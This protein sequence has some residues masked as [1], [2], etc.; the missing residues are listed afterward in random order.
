M[1]TL[2]NSF[3]NPSNFELAW[4]RVASNQGCAGVDGETIREFGQH[5]E[6]NLLRLLQAVARGTYQPLPLR[7]IFI[8]KPGGGWRELRVPAVRD[9]IVQQALL[10]VLH[11]ALEPEFEPSSYAYRPG[12]SHLMAVD[13]VGRWRDQGYS[14]VLDADIVK[15][16]D[17]IQHPRLVTEVRERLAEPWIID[18]IKG[19]I[20]AGVLT[21]GGIVLPQRGVP[22]GAVISPL[23]SNIYL[24]DFDEVLADQLWKLVRFADDFVLMARTQ[25]HIQAGH[26]QVKHLLEAAGLELHPEKTQITHFEQ[27]FRFLGHTFVGDLIVPNRPRPRSPEPQARISTPELTLI[28]AEATGRGPTAMQRALVEALKQSEQPIPPPLFV[29]LGY[30]VRPHARIEIN[31]KELNWREDMASLY[32]VEQGTYLKKGKGRFTLKA[33][34]TKEVL[35][36]PIEEV[37]RILV[38]GNIHLSSAVINSCLKRQ[39]PIIFLSQTGE[40]KGHLW[41]AEITDLTAQA[42]QFARQH[43]EDFQC[44]TARAIVYGKLWNSKLLLVR[45]NYKRQL[46]EVSTTIERLNAALETLAFVDSSHSLEQLRGY[47]GNG[48]S[49]YFQTFN[50]LITNPGFSWQGRNFHPPTDPVNS[51]LSF[52]YTL[53]FNNVFSLLLV[54]GLNPYLGNLHRAERQKAYLAFDLMEEFRSPIVD[55][56]VLKLINKKIIRPMD[57]TWPQDNNGVYLTNPARRVFLRH[58]EQRMTESIT[59]P[60]V[61]EPVTYRRVIQLQ[62]Q[63]YKRAVLGN[64]PYEA[65]RRLK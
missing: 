64:Q 57:F 41:S 21:P 15:Y 53:L 60:D 1:A 17:R 26:T 29:V 31:S 52:G 20:E 63:R 13:Q 27:G 24:D 48:A 58:F 44:L 42:Q 18:L 36:I 45:Q 50:H 39:I 30:Q 49:Q 32:I 14:W 40:Y 47:E 55:T 46:P 2:E 56:L 62:V 3:L 4:D 28:H 35:E 25:P 61:K 9:R 6:R 5:K 33:P 7:Q 8:P 12:R 11:P 22:Q 51:L 43:D 10:Q 38:F 19:W 65:F 34:K 37:E 54:E 16:F 23:L 59:H